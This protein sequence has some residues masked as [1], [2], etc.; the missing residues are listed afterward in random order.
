MALSSNR[1]ML[2]CI[3]PLPVKF[4]YNYGW[5]YRKIYLCSIVGHAVKTPWS[6]GIF[7]LHRAHPQYDIAA[8]VTLLSV[9][10][11]YPRE[12]TP[13]PSASVPCGFG[14]GWDSMS[15]ATLVIKETHPCHILVKRLPFVKTGKIRLQRRCFKK[16][17]LWL[18]HLCVGNFTAV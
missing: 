1:Y 17:L 9:L 18:L 4:A 6:S 7:S 13:K 11:P 5:Q 2:N 12:H 10:N 3:G 15:L 16:Y 14:L 8:S